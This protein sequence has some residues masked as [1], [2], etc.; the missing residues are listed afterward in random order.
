MMEARFSTGPRR[1]SAF[2]EHCSRPRR[3]ER[4]RNL[5][6]DIIGVVAPCDERTTDRQE[7]SMRRLTRRQL[8]AAAVAFGACRRG[9]RAMTATLTVSGMV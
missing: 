7:D 4:D 2:H 3:R 5:S 6:G 1:R 8:I 9:P